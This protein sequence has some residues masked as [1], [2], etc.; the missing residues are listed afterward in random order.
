MACFRDVRRGCVVCYP[1][2]ELLAKVLTAIRGRKVIAKTRKVKNVTNLRPLRDM[3]PVD[4]FIECAENAVKDVVPQKKDV[5]WAEA[6]VAKA[7]KK[8]IEIQKRAQDP[9][10]MER[11]RLLHMKGYY[12]RRIK[13]F[14][15]QIVALKKAKAAKAEVMVIEQKLADAERHYAGYAAECAGFPDRRFRS[16]KEKAKSQMMPNKLA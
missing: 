8:R 6:A 13:E 12:G 7:E 9:K 15:A 5:E 2:V 14:K 10:E 3:K 11:Q 1:P 16:Y 4:F